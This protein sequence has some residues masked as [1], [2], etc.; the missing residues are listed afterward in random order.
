MFCFEH[1][2]VLKGNV[3]AKPVKTRKTQQVAGFLKFKENPQGACLKPENPCSSLPMSSS[4][5]ITGGV[6]HRGAH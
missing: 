6:E 1:V 2:V 3:F 5:L 4:S